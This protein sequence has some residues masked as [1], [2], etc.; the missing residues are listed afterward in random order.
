MRGMNDNDLAWSLGYRR[1]FVAVFTSCT[2]PKGPNWDVNPTYV[3]N[4]LTGYYIEYEKTFQSANAMGPRGQA[5]TTDG[6]TGAGYPYTTALRPVTDLSDLFK[7]ERVWFQSAKFSVLDALKS[8][9]TYQDDANN[10]A[11]INS[12]SDPNYGAW[13]SSRWLNGEIAL[14]GVNYFRPG[15]FYNEGGKIVD[16]LK[17][18]VLVNGKSN[19]G[20][21]SV[22]PDLPFWVDGGYELDDQLNSLSVFAGAAQYVNGDTNKPLVRYPIKCT[23]WFK[24]KGIS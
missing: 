10:I 24:L 11:I 21:Q 19:Q 22:G 3:A 6:A 16:M 1:S 4:D 14:S 13:N 20:D 18:A 15:I 8:G 17:T 23:L 12:I 2:D 9:S 7:S 5:P